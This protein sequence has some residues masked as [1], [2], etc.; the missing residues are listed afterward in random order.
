[1]L[2]QI[3]HANFHSC[4]SVNSTQSAAA[5]NVNEKHITSSAP[6]DIFQETPTHIVENS[7]GK[8]FH[9]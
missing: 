5:G 9:E 7:R 4:F 2:M 3:A 8:R 1:M 6:D